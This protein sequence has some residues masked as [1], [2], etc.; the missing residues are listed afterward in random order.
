MDVSEENVPT[1]HR[2]TVSILIGLKN[3]RRHRQNGQTHWASV[4]KRKTDDGF[5]LWIASKCIEIHQLFTLAYQ[6]IFC[7]LW[8]NSTYLRHRTFYRQRLMWK[9]FLIPSSIMLWFTSSTWQQK[10]R[11]DFSAHFPLLHTDTCTRCE[12]N[13]WN[14]SSRNAWNE[15]QRTLNEN[16]KLIQKVFN[17]FVFFSLLIENTFIMV[18]CSIHK[19]T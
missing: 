8:L 16:V 6:I 19:H 1:I 13:R 15:T 17:L 3:S 11:S 5:C 2:R 4:W 9:S 12:F 7:W 10:H 14:K 18:L